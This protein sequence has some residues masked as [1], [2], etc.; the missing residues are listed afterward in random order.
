MYE[1]SSSFCP[2]LLTNYLFYILGVAMDGGG[3]VCRTRFVDNVTE[4]KAGLKSSLKT[5]L[6]PCE[7]NFSVTSF[8]S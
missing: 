1:I 4:L 5:L 8:N 7:E 3:G 2:V 6:K